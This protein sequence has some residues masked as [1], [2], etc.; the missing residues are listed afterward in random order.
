M[1]IEPSDFSETNV[2]LLSK[3]FLFMKEPSGYNVYSKLSPDDVFVWI[4]FELSII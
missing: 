3:V 4:D 1:V 2:L